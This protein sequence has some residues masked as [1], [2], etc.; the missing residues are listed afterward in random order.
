VVSLEIL[1]WVVISL[2][3]F[4]C[5]LDIEVGKGGCDDEG[6]EGRFLLLISFA[7]RIYVR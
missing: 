1:L 5:Y 4:S 2:S 7:V 3:W 6:K